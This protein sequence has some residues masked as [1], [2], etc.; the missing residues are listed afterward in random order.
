MGAS[1]N[2]SAGRPTAASF[3]EVCPDGFALLQSVPLP[4]AVVDADGVIHAVN[5]AWKKATPTNFV[6]GTAYCLACERCFLTGDNGLAA[7]ESGI[8][9]V[10]T[11]QKDAFVAD[12]SCAAG[13]GSVRLTVAPLRSSHMAGAVITHA[14][15][16]TG[17]A[18]ETP[19]AA[20]RRR[21]AEKM[22]AVGRLVG[23]VAHDFANLLTMISGYSEIV[24]S[25]MGQDEPL[26]PELE[27][28]RK[29]ANRGSRLTA[30]LLGFTRGQA[31]E[32][33]IL[34]LNTLIADMEKMLR[35]IIGEHIE[36]ATSLA[37]DLG[38]VNADPGQ[39]EQVIMNLVLNARDAMPP[40]GG[41]ITIETANVELGGGEAAARDVTP[42]PY[43]VLAFT[44][45]GQGMDA[46]T[47]SRLFEPFF[48]T[49]EKG[50]GT[51]LGLSTVYGIARQNRGGVWAHSTPGQGSTFTLCLPRV[52]AAGV[53]AAAPARAPASGSETIL[54]VEDE[55]GVRRLL[56]H[57]LSR[58]GYAVLE[59]RDGP[60]ALELA[61]SYTGPIHLLLTDMV[62]P[63]MSGRE[64][65]ERFQKLRPATKVIYMSGYTDDVLLRTGAIGPGMSFLQKP[66]RP[67]VLAARVR[68]VLDGRTRSETRVPG[69][70]GRR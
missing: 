51:G 66:L 62:M 40:G 57:I 45:T 38:R 14:F 46:Q 24:L 69:A 29:A 22:E 19:E 58:R 26:R 65:A 61:G 42:G 2:Q 48:T 49:K 53:P 60:S 4:L 52:K 39:M 12:F 8:R 13:E 7:I 63:R 56:E 3:A 28:I 10:L 50:K 37:Y 21:Q 35:P 1:S 30:Q 23:G 68:D 55:D 34:D 20:D 6:P 18:R 54:L 17:G 15:T 5:D 33:R 59:A 27:E 44:D 67:D 9:A 64:L 43:V 31:F 47:M 32:P 25:R 36:L 41:R 16:G 11:G 70:G